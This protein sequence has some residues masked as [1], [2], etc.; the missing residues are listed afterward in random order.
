[1]PRASEKPQALVAD[2]FSRFQFPSRRR[3]QEARRAHHL[4]HQPPALGVAAEPHEGDEAARGSRA[5]DFSVRGA[6]LSRRRRARAVR[7]PSARR[8]RARAGARRTV[9]CA[10]S[11]SIAAG[12]SW[13][14]CPAAGRTRS[15][16]C[17]RS[18]AMRS[19]RSPRG[20][21]EAQF[22]IA[23]A[24]SLDDRLFSSMKWN[25]VAARRGARA[26]PTTCWRFRTWRS[27]RR[28]RPPCRPRCTG[29]RW[30]SCTGLS[31]LTYRL[32]RRFLLVENVAMVNLIA[33][34]R[35]VPELIQDDCTAENIAAET[36]SLLTNHE[37][38]EETRRG[39][40]RGAREARR[41]RRERPRGGGGAGGGARRVRRSQTIL[42]FRV[43]GTRD[44]IGLAG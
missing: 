36:L 3:G 38:A 14:C 7:R 4:L 26:E 30:W 6:D 33:G 17:C 21:R 25:G 35:I 20:C 24:P 28:A 23:R 27:P 22:V 32:G 18:C 5:R 16:G 10:R 15:S 2:R 37:R 29:A 34:R 31:P 9:F 13:R 40:C 41:P 1:M 39:A 42:Q 43:R 12:R 8:S 19:R 44:L 11:A